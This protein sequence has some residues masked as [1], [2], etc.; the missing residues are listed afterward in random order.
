MCAKEAKYIIDGFDE[1]LEYI[2]NEFS[3]Y[4]S[5]LRFVD[6]L[7]FWKEN[8]MDC[9][10]AN[11]FDPRELLE[12]ITEINYKLVLIIS[13]VDGRL[14]ARLTSLY[15]LICICRKQP[16]RMR[17]KIRLTCEDAVNF[18]KLCDHIKQNYLHDDADFIWDHLR[19]LD[20]IEFSEERQVFG[21]SMLDYRKISNKKSSKKAAQTQSSI[22]SS[23]EHINPE[24]DIRTALDELASLSA[25]YDNLRN[26]LQLGDV[27]D[28]SFGIESNET[29]RELIDQAK[30]MSH[31]HKI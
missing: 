17:R 6:F 23:E 8:Y 29:V 1:D 3:K 2:T 4:S 11:R 12:A 20:A 27:V 26:M 25:V 24:S 7:N 21:P 22:E 10:F 5:T 16:E 14:Q 31:G 13:D 15:M 19:E 9:L 18:N 28:E 30:S